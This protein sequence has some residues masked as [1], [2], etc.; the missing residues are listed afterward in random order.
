[1]RGAGPALLWV[2]S[3]PVRDCHSRGAFV[4]VSSWPGRGRGRS[5]RRHKLHYTD[6]GKGADPARVGEVREGATGCEGA[7]EAARDG[8][9]AGC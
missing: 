8:D 6:E 3:R 1:V 4:R 2:L 5:A 9:G 7:W